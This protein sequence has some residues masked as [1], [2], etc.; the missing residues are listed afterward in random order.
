MIQVNHHADG[1]VI[2]VR[3][4]P[5]ARRDAVVGEHNGA[6]KVAVSAPPDKGKANL[7]VAALL[8]DCL[9]LKKTQVELFAGPTSKDKKFLIRGTSADV[10]KSRLAARCSA[11]PSAAE[12][13]RASDGREHI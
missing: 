11:T 10:V 12:A 9:G 2:A 3:A 5:G 1:C 4:Q 6:L 7:A 8:C 13:P